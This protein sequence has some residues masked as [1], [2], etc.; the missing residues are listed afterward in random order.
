MINLAPKLDNCS[1]SSAKP[2][3]VKLDCSAQSTNGMDKNNKTPEIRCKIEDIEVI[4]ELSEV[5]INT[6]EEDIQNIITK[7]DYKSNY[8]IVTEVNTIITASGLKGLKKNKKQLLKSYKDKLK[9]IYELN[10]YAHILFTTE[11][12]NEAIEVLK[13]NTKLFPEEPKTYINL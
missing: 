5:N 6:F 9:S 12:P 3:G 2:A 8:Q 7:N 1:L 13:I 10:T 11:K 4:E